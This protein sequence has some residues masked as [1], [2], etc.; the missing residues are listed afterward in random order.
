[1]GAPT[2]SGK[3]VCAILAILKVFKE[4]PKEK[5]IFVTPYD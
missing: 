4:N 5:V 3:T 1:L 2:G